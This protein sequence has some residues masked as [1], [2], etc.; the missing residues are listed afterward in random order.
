MKTLKIGVILFALLFAAMTMVPMMSAAN[1]DSSINPQSVN[2]TD[3]TM[4]ISGVSL[5]V[6]PSNVFTLDRSLDTQPLT[7][8]QFIK[9]NK[10]NI[11][12]LSQQFGKEAAQKMTNEQYTHL[13]QN[14]RLLL[15]YVPPNVLQIWGYDVYLWPYQSQSAS[16]ND[17]SASPVN[18]IVF[19]NNAF[20]VEN[21]L[22]NHG[23][24]AAQGWDEWGFHGR[25]R[26]SLHWTDSTYGGYIFTQVQDGS[27]WGSRYH[28]VLINGDYSNSLRNSWSYGNCH[29]EY[30]NGATHIIYAN[31]WNDGRNRI[32]S[33][34]SGTS[35]TYWVALYNSV[36]G[37]FD[38]W[39][40]IF[41]R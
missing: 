34:L 37:Y 32:Y 20:Q 2:L 39:G 3:K 23:W 29:H 30:W 12:F 38:G 14:S 17:Q 15:Q 41:A 4:K 25:S 10:K 40:L 8:E 19:N 31:G 7:K 13:T 5:K 1:A 6:A 9:S 16:T 33:S 22:L 11:E 35:S 36:S 24:E 26:S 18:F 21:Y 27:Y 28:A